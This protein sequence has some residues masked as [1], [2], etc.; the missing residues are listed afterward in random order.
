MDGLYSPL[1]DQSL[2]NVTTWLLVH[3][4]IYDVEQMRWVDLP[5]FARIEVRQDDFL[6]L[7]AKSSMEI[8]SGECPAMHSLIVQ[9]QARY[10]ASTPEDTEVTP[11]TII[12]LPDTPAADGFTETASAPAPRRA[13]RKRSQVLSSPARVA[14]GSSKWKRVRDSE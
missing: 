11:Q 8:D 2:R 13:K 1:S 10:C 12:N 9:L 6:M 3:F 4:S 5:T 7:R 14:Q